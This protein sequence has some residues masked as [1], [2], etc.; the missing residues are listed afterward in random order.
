MKLLSGKLDFAG[1]G[2][3][4]RSWMDTILKPDLVCVCLCVSALY[5]TL[6]AC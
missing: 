5:Q 4:T 6:V 2:G 1:W 3:F